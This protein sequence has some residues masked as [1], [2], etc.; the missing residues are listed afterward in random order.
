MKNRQA[1]IKQQER[2]LQEVAKLGPMRK[3]SV[4]EYSPTTV[5]KDGSR[6][7]RG[8]YLVY[9]CKKKGKT[10]G[11]HLRGP[12]QEKTY[13]E[14]IARFRRFEELIA[15]FGEISEQLA[16]RDAAESGKKKGFS[17]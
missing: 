7:S 8:P 11:K 12:G 17:V 6:K 15:Q 16:D 3:G 13:R 1:L 9:T 14:Q 2:I 4:S 10:R 5:R